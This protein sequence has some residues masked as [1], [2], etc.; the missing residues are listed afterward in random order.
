MTLLS[1]KYFISAARHRN[2]TRAAQECFVTQPALSRAIHELE[3]EMDCQLFIRTSRSVELTAAGECCLAV[4]RRILNQVSRMPEKVREAARLKEAPMRVGYVIYD[5]LM[6]LMGLLSEQQPDGTDR[7]DPLPLDPHYRSCS[8]AKQQF[9]DGEL[10][11]LLLPEPC[12]ADLEGAESTVLRRVGMALIVPRQNPLFG[13]ESLH[14]NELRS[15]RFIGWSRAETPLL[16]DEYEDVFRQS[17]FE[18][19]IVGYAEKLGDMAIQVIAHDAV[20]FGSTISHRKQLENIRIIPVSDCTHKFGLSFVWHK[21]DTTQRLR[22]IR[23]RLE[24]ANP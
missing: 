8:V 22:L 18:P 2:F 14:M 16:E 12:A 7:T 5:H 17:G 10:D 23:R 1:L 11:A 13:R 4:A 19:N 6:T 24:K 15:E 21:G 20:G 9:R 3:E